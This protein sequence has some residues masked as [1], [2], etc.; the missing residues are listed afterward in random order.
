MPSILIVTSFSLV[1]LLILSANIAF[2]NSVIFAYL[3]AKILFK[4][5]ASDKILFSAVAS[6]LYWLEI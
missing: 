6:P 4:I 3:P 1:I 2:L 5:N